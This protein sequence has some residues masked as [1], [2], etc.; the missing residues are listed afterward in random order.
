MKKTTDRLIVSQLEFLCPDPTLL[1]KDR[2]LKSRSV[3]SKEFEAAT[4]FGFE[5]QTSDGG[6]NTQ[7]PNF[8]SLNSKKR[9]GPT[10]MNSPSHSSL[11]LPSF[12]IKKYGEAS[13]EIIRFATSDLRCL[14]GL[15]SADGSL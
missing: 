8:P 5:T 11:P 7:T 2:I 4:P 6:N 14:L 3:S 13:A 10:F 12:A 9:A 1:P 15:D